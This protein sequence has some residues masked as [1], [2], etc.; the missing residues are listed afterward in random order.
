[1]GEIFP[2]TVILSLDFRNK[3]FFSTNFVIENINQFETPTTNARNEDD[4][5]KLIHNRKF[6]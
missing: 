3:H 6:T 1:M 4:S 5:V 2:M